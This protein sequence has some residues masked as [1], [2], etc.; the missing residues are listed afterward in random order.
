MARPKST[1]KNISI[2]EAG[3]SHNCQHSKTHRISKGNV[4]LTIKDGR[5]REHFC[6]DCGL[7]F[8][9]ND[10]KSLSAILEKLEA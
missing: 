9:E 6:K 3:A 4:R 8:L 1:I 5:S 7:R 2:T 10:I